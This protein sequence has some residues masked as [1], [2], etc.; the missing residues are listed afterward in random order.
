[1]KT[2][3][4]GAPFLSRRQFLKQ[5]A[6]AGGAVAAPFILPASALGRGGAVAPS[7]RIVMG[8]IGLGG[9]G[10]GVL[11]WMLGEKDMQFVAIC[12]VRK[13][14]R[15][16]IKKM[17][18]GRYGNTDCAMYR[19]LRE[20]LAERADIDA[21]LIATGDRWHAL[22]SILAMKAGK[23][24]YCEKPGTM[25]I[26]EGQALVETE[27]RYGRVFQTGTQRRSE[28][29]FAFAVQ[30]ARLGRLGQVHTVRAHISSWTAT[31]RFTWLAAENE[32]PK[33]DVDWDLW[34]GPVPWRPYNPSY[35]RGGW[36]GY[37]DFHTMDIGEWGSHTV[38]HCQMALDADHTSP[39]EYE[40]PGN[41]N[42]EGLV[43][44]YANGVKL[45]LTR[46]GWRGSCGVKFEGTEGWVS[47]AD[48]YEKPDVSSP[49]LL[50]DYKKIVQDYSA[51]YQRPLNHVRDFFDCVKTRRAT[52]AHASSAHR[53]MSTCHVANI[54]LWLGRSLKWDPVKEEFVGDPEANR[55]RS[56]AL[57][58]P[59][60]L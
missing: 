27:R 2:E 12:D 32:P 56:R 16:A 58:E 15:E 8:G 33:E 28:G 6:L 17:V 36:R 10:A 54:C 21:V 25:T 1:M 5:A 51:Q 46:E 60:Q 48:G 38:S 53:S 59:W 24:V 14:R 31:P 7:D 13:E 44:R 50:S 39:V 52:V 23:D 18:D 30:L 3:K 49:A 19:D 11:N 29:K 47:V 57:R 22:A 55:L 40:H 41:D 34:L 4:S 45:V 20:F 26:A 37:Y 35:V 9:R 43:A 42:G